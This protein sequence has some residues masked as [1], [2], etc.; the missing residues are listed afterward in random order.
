MGAYGDLAARE[1]ATMMVGE[2]VVQ[3][4]KQ[5][6]AARVGNSHEIWVPH[7]VYPTRGDDRWIALAIRTDEEWLRLVDLMGGPEWCDSELTSGHARRERRDEIDAGVAAWTSRHDDFQLV[8][9]LQGA[10]LSANRSMRAADLLEDEHLL[11]RETITQLTH[12]VHGGRMTVGAPW[13]FKNADVRFREWSK[14]LGADNE[15]V[16]CGLLGISESQYA[17]WIRDEVIY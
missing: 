14:S 12:P 3:A 4:L 7:G 6:E 2:S 5:G 17:E 15:E 11:K 16:I 13:R 8:E 10:S 9:M 1:V